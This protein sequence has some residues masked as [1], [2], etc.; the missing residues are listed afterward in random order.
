VKLGKQIGHTYTYT[1]N[2]NVLRVSDECQTLTGKVP[3]KSLWA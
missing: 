3:Q 2:K 1:Y